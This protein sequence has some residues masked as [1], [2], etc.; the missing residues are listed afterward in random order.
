MK[1]FLVLIGLII[2]MDI[3][4]SDTLSLDR[5]AGQFAH[6]YTNLD[7]HAEL[8]DTVFDIYHFH[9]ATQVITA[10]FE[11]IALFGSIFNIHLGPLSS[12]YRSYFS[13]STRFD[14]IKYTVENSLTP[15]KPIVLQPARFRILTSFS[16]GY[17]AIREI[18]KHP[19]YY[20]TIDALVL[21]D[22]LHTNSDSLKMKE[23]MADFVRFARDAVAGRKIMI[24]TH[25]SIETEGYQ[26]TTQTAQYLIKK[27]DLQPHTIDQRDTIGQAFVQYK[28]GNLSI[29]GYRGDDGPSHM[30][31]F[32]GIHISLN[33]LIRLS[34]R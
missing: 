15:V 23:Q 31:H 20:D 33:N 16:A 11:E 14:Q 21:A 8:P 32:F 2:H 27:L 3:D 10:Q 12:P 24:I 25:S 13:D 18:L 1:L 4:L 17:A 7:E 22:G 26:S 5:A 6:F 9:G 19:I 28:E 30:K 34:K 29:T